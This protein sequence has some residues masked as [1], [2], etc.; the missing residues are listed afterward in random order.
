MQNLHSSRGKRLG[1]LSQLLLKGLPINLANAIA[2]PNAQLQY[3]SSESASW[4]VEAV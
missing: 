1:K 2:L 4:S 3:V